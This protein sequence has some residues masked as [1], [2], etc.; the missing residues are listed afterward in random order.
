[1]K[2]FF[3]TDSSSKIGYGHVTRCLSLARTL[4]DLGHEV[5]FICKTLPGNII[6]TIKG[7]GFIVHK[8]PAHMHT[9]I[10]HTILYDAQATKE[11]IDKGC[12]FL[13]VDHYELDYLWQKYL[14]SNCERILVIDDL[15]NRRHLADILVD[16]NPDISMTSRY[17]DYLPKHCQIL[18][19]SVYTLLGD[20]V[21]NYSY[22]HSLSADK[23]NI[24]ISFGGSDEYDL[25]SKVTRLM[26]KLGLK[27]EI[28]VI[29][30]KANLHKEP[31]EAVCKKNN[32]E[33]YCEPPHYQQLLSQA[34]GFIGACGTSTWECFFLGIPFIMI[35]WTKNQHLTAAY[36][37]EQNLITYVGNCNQLENF[38]D[39]FQRSLDAF[40]K[41][42]RFETKKITD[43]CQELIDGQG[44]LK[45]ARIMENC[46]RVDK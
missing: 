41:R 1:M 44:P 6:E 10:R 31:V 29:V 9:N 12:D 14:R 17:Q 24:I 45:I 37:R 30:A 4:I 15:C 43:K 11:V 38:D 35:T 42:P 18:R 34:T 13:C 28:T 26:I 23:S 36:L 33:F 2:V 19:G 39:S 22:N 8:I 32:V 27:N 5:E 40:L 7:R 46:L 16:H 21:L 20:H 3:R 25:S